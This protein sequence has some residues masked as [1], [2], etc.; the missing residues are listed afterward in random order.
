MKTANVA[1]PA[2]AGKTATSAAY[3]ACMDQLPSLPSVIMEVLALC[4]RDSVD[5]RDIVKTV[6]KDPALTARLL[7]IGN[8]PLYAGRGAISTLDDAV[9]RLGTKAVIV[10]ALAFSL[11][12]ALPVSAKVGEYDVET[13]WRRAMIESIAAR[14]FSQRLQRGND[15][16]AF[17]CGLLMDI[18]IPLFAK[19]VPDEYADIVAQMD[20]GH[21]DILGEDSVLEGNHAD[22]AGFLL[23]E[24]RLPESLAAAV[25][26]HHDPDRLG[27]LGDP[28]TTELARILHLAHLSAGVILSDG[29]AMRLRQLED[30][31][32]AWF[33]K[34]G[35]FVDGVLGSIERSVREFAAAIRFDVKGLS[36][37]KMLELAR[38]ELI[39]VSVAAASALS[40]A[41][42]KVAELENKATTDALT[43]LCNRGFFEAAMTAEWDRRRGGEGS[44]PLGLLMVDVDLFKRV[45]DTYG[46]GVGDE[47]LRVIGKAMRAVVR[48]A[49]VVC[50]YG[51]EEFAVICPGTGGTTL[52]AVAERIRKAIEAAPI[53]VGRVQEHVTVS[54]GASVLTS[55]R[56]AETHEALVARTDEALYQAKREGRNRIVGPVEV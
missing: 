2:R 10:A 33:G 46:H 12:G 15:S 48:D 29:R 22:L 6:S 31:V 49:D 30:K 39:N 41:E 37:T 14:T 54:I 17:V 32:A 56:C 25:T 45:N 19:T 53:T 36:T 11:T 1:R 47:V 16:E 4:R 55:R 35:S 24:W 38:V 18:G 44:G 52:R 7:K 9:V 51:G 27:E 40:R 20:A 28:A 26:A 5:V 8:S 3:L 13:F 50:R 21:P 43:G 23:R 42:N 34:A